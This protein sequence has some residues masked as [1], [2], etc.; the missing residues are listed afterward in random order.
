MKIQYASING[1]NKHAAGQLS[2]LIT[3]GIAQFD[4]DTLIVTL[5]DSTDAT[6]KMRIDVLLETLDEAN[7]AWG[8]ITSSDPAA[9]EAQKVLLIKLGARPE[10]RIMRV[11]WLDMSVLTKSQASR[12]IDCA[13]D[14]IEN[15]H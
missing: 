9:S 1:Y 2:D 5:P 14:L 4:R 15:G 3:N 12:L 11:E 13:R 6:T 10:A 8:A 7:A